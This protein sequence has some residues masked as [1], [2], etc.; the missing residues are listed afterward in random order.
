MLVVSR[1]RLTDEF[2]VNGEGSWERLRNAVN[3]ARRRP[4][5][6]R[7]WKEEADEL[8]LVQQ[9][10]HRNRHHLMTFELDDAAEPGAFADR[11]RKSLDG[12]AEAARPSH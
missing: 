1:G 6:E 2:E 3:Q 5:E 10:I 8:R 9:W 12:G 4:A 11:I 7:Y